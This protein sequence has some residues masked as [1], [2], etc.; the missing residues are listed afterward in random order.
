M[1]K[2]L[3]PFVPA[4]PGGPVHTHCDDH[5]P[6][7]HLGLGDVSLVALASV[8]LFPTKKEGSAL[9]HNATKEL[10]EFSVGAAQQTFIVSVI[11]I[12]L[13]Y[14]TFISSIHFLPFFFPTAEST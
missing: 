5:K 12:I 6:S 9:L 14:V 2:P 7:G 1:L 4:G 8:S 13:Y 11:F 10:K 3:Q